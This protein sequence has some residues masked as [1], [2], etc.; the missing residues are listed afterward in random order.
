MT[1]LIALGIAMSMSAPNEPGQKEVVP[2]ADRPNVFKLRKYEPRPNPTFSEARASLP[3]PVVADHPD[4]E[5]LYWKAWDLAFSHLMQPAPESGF[6]S[7]F[8]DP[9]FNNNTFQW[10]TCFMLM[11]A[12]YAEP[13]FH[14]IGSLDNFY[15]RQHD[16][17][18]I[19]REIVRKTGQDF[20]F[21]SID[22][23]I[24][25]PLFSWVEWEN[26]LLTGDKSRFKDV[27]PPLARYYRWLRNNRRRENGLYWNTGLGSGEDDLVRS[28]T[29]YS[30][31]DMTAQQAANAYYIA[32][33]A[34]Q[35]GEKQAESYFDKE[36]RELSK[37]VND[38]MWDRGTG[39]Y[40]DLKQDG[41]S[42]GIKT[43]LGFWPMLAHIASSDQAGKLVEHLRDPK[44]FWRPNVVPALAADE[45]GY[46]A[47]GQYWNGAVWAPTNFMVVK[48]L[49]NYGYEDLA[50]QIT[51]RYLGNM[52]SVLD[53]TGTIWENYAPESATGHGVRDMVGWS[54]DGPIA[55][56]IE[57]I[58]G[59]R[60]LASSREVFWRPRLAGENGIRKLMVGSAHVDLIAGAVGD[61]SRELTMTTDQPITI[62]VDSGIGK[63]ITLKLAAGETKRRVKSAT[64][65]L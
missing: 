10:D 49:E 65:D 50:S 28:K 18:Y 64:L 22:D 9:A 35:V 3:E 1:A 30:W 63:P 58:L 46:R 20:V 5:T 47:D 59:I 37:L 56:L 36:N 15:A 55:L 62:R 24:N 61:G 7:N 25:P 52:S 2:L 16:D 54:G 19:C 40:F 38:S 32:R 13:S 21:G 29:A 17:G 31:V 45:E 4:W 43:V 14:A 57:N 33:I 26:Y 34:E 27:L 42:T 6:V 44:E 23:T 41:A 11:Y 51:A 12:H 48:G 8:I 53:R 39:F 60:G